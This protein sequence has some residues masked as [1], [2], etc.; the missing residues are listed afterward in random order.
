V[1]YKLTRELQMN[2]TIRQDWQVATQPGFVYDATSF[3][4]GLHL[5][6]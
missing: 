6:R 1:V 2:A 4:L 5:Q 3:L